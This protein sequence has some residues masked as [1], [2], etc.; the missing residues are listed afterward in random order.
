MSKLTILLKKIETWM[1]AVAFAEA[2]EPEK[3]LKM[4]GVT[5]KKKTRSFS[6][7]DLT[8]AITFAE[9]GEH[10]MAREYLGVKDDIPQKYPLTIP[11][12]KL[13]VGTV[14]FPEPVVIPGVKVWCGTA[15]LT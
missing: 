14:M 8:T 6:L 9:A 10:G 5:P 15:S 7:E 2:N 12:V 3:A 13:W 4:I 11:G 1:S